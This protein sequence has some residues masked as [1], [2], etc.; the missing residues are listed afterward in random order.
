MKETIL[1][2]IVISDLHC[3]Y[4]KK[5][6]DTYLTSDLLR[7]PIGNHPVESL[8][9]IV[10]KEEDLRAD[11]TLSPG[12]FTNE[13]DVQ[14]FISGWNYVH[15]IN[16]GF[17]SS[18]IIATVGNHDVDSYGA[19]SN[20]SLDIA[21]AIKKNFPLKE[22]RERELFWSRG[23]VFVEREN[24]RV[25]VINSSHFHHNKENA[26]QGKVDYN[27]LDYVKEYLEKIQ[28]NKIQIA[29]SHHHP[30]NH[31]RLELG[32]MDKIVNG[33][34]LLELLCKSKF[35]LFI[36]G[37]KHDALLRNYSSAGN[38]HVLPI[39]SA[40]SFSAKTNIS[41]TSMRN[42][43]HQIDISK[44][45][46]ERAKGVIRTWTFFSKQGWKLSYDDEAFPPHSGFGYDGTIPDLV[47]KVASIIGSKTIVQWGEILD[48][49]PEIKN[50]IPSQIKELEE[51][52]DNVG[53]ALYRR[54]AAEIPECIFNKNYQ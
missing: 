33:S 22:S 49:I 43:F 46:N 47:K 18:E 20:Y 16:E 52:L 30:I 34:E 37:H 48:Q 14:G 21:K 12:D 11:L 44:S 38:S 23:C 27:L 17:E 2:L 40:G 6:N 28:D 42:Q 7:T 26:K 29:L 8:L 15:E 36:H 41:W 54:K 53:L 13:C 50:L 31:S 9:K 25:L 24:F 39:L 19:N 4:S 51:E 32:E 45:G 5:G 3:H 35:D 10:E 1:K